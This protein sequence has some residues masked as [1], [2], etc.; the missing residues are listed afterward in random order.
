MTPSGPTLRALQLLRQ[1]SF[2]VATLCDSIIV[3]GETNRTNALR[4]LPNA[5]QQLRERTQAAIEA[6]ESM[7]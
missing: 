7:P 4:L 3:G 5:L 1:A 2:Q 6:L